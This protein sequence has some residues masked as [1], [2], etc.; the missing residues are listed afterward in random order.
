MVLILYFESKDVP[1]C[2]KP[3][4]SYREIADIIAS[5]IS[6]FI[7]EV[8]ASVSY[9]H[10]YKVASVTLIHKSSSKF[11]FENYKPISVT[12]FLSKVFEKVLH[13]RISE[14]HHKHNAI[15]EDQQGFLKN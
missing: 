6:S 10:F 13:S 11:D 14:F 1:I 5:V 9:P 2:K 4:C 15:Y 3:S 7:N 12:P 8:I